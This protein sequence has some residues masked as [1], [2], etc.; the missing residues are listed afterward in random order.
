M[1]NNENDI[2]L[3]IIQFLSNFQNVIIFLKIV[4]CKECQH[5]NNIRF[6]SL[7]MK[8]PKYLGFYFINS[9][10]F[11]P[12]GMTK[13]VFLISFCSGLF[14][15]LAGLSLYVIPMFRMKDLTVIPPVQSC[16]GLQVISIHDITFNCKEKRK[17]GL[18][19]DN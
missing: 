10:K 17:I 16:L 8:F 14:F 1:T 6:K 11:C 9:L 18:V 12:P 15:Y 5:H 4:P 7:T 13:K 2:V 3:N 19:L